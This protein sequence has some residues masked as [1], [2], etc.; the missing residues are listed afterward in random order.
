M[1][2]EINK[3]FHSVKFDLLLIKKFPEKWL[4]TI[5]Y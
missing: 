5:N 3:I 1:K 4:K 2:I